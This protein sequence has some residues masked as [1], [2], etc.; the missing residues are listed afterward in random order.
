M[1]CPYC[2]CKNTMDEFDRHP[3]HETARLAAGGFGRVF[4]MLVA[5]RDGIQTP[6]LEDAI[7]GI[8]RCAVHS[9]E[10]GQDS[11]I[12]WFKPKHAEVRELIK[13]RDASREAG[14]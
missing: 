4:S 7:E 14:L 1:K 5:I 11:F 6:E 2:K 10:P 8:R 3:N 12:A 13:R 9:T